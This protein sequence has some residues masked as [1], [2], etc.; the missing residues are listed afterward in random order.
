MAFYPLQVSGLS[1]YSTPIGGEVRTT[2]HVETLVRRDPQ[3]TLMLLA[4][5]TGHA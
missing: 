1:G 5:E 4:S 2:A 3:D